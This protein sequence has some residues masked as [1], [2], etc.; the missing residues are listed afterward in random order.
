[1]YIIIN[2][3]AR[4][5]CKNIYIYPFLLSDKLWTLATIKRD[6]TS[7]FVHGGKTIVLC[8][9]H[10]HGELK[11]IYYICLSSLVATWYPARYLAVAGYW[12]SGAYMEKVWDLR[13]QG[14]PENSVVRER[15][16]KEKRRKKR[17]KIEK[18]RK[19]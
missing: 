10:I 6:V 9:V 5:T 17:K 4:F 16:K 7:L 18:S 2:V 15:D 14:S 3:N 19:K 11:Q 1:M 13:D 12:I 8:M